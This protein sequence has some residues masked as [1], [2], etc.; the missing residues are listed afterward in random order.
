MPPLRAL[1]QCDETTK[2]NKCAYRSIAY[3]KEHETQRARGALL[4]RRYSEGLPGKR[5]YGGNEQIDK[6]ETL[7]Q[8]RALSLFG[9]AAEEWAVR[10]TL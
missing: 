4:A 3:A 10:L 1:V 9:L 5:Y 2:I 8:D 7:C 6:M